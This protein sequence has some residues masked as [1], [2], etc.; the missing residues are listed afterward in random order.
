MKR[1]GALRR[2]RATA[3]VAG[4]ASA[5][6]D[7]TPA[8]TTAGRATDRAVGARQRAHTR[9]FRQ[10]YRGLV[11]GASP[12]ACDYAIVNEE[13]ARIIHILSW[14]GRPCPSAF[15]TGPRHATDRAVGATLRNRQSSQRRP[16]L[17]TISAGRPPP[18]PVPAPAAP[19][20]P[21]TPPI[22]GWASRPSPPATTT[23][24]STQPDA[25][26][27]LLNYQLSTFNF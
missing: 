3:S 23:R 16:R 8:P 12:V 17:P 26:D 15:T 21:S 19:A 9:R 2:A 22:V 5:E 10:Q 24:P 20:P 13:R 4:T 18:T 1:R 14:D 27:R 25:G 7:C 6:P 11:P